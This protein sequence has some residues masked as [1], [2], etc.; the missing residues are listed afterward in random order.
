MAIAD[1]YTFTHQE[2]AEMMVKSQDIHE[3][4]W[5]LYV[6]FGLKGTNVKTDESMAPAALVLVQKL[7][8]QRFEESSPLAVDAAEVNPVPPKKA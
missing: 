6:E 4:N 2:L 8:L 3:G 1:R 7:G 5:G